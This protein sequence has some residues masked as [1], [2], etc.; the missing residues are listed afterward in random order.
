MYFEGWRLGGDGNS[1]GGGGPLSLIL[2]VK[3]GYP[4]SCLVVLLSDIDPLRH[5]CLNS[6]E[7]KAFV[8]KRSHGANRSG[9]FIYELLTL[10]LGLGT[11][12][13]VHLSAD[14]GAS[15][16]NRPE[17]LKIPPCSWPVVQHAS[18]D[19]VSMMTA[20]AETIT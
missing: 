3:R 13:M 6:S 8:K 1:P 10:R 2:M 7:L 19:P 16:A 15:S 5:F 14:N 11:S 12:Y 17:R 20:A 18:V 4:V 9:T